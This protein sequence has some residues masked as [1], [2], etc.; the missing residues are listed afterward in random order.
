VA[1]FFAVGAAAAGFIAALIMTALPGRM[2][3]SARYAA[4]LVALMVLTTGA[5][6]VLLFSQYAPYYAQWW[7]APFHSWWFDAATSTFAGIGFYYGAI[8]LPMLLP[9]G[10][11]ALLAFAALLA[12][13]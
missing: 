3:W 7:P 5:H 8:G 6:V 2:P 4:A 12:R 10:L 13:R 9:L 1:A 11:P